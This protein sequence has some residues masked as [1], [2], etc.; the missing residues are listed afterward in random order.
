VT[1]ATSPG[2][3]LLEVHPTWSQCTVCDRY[4]TSDSAFTAHLD[5]EVSRTC[6]DPAT[7]RSG[8][9]RLVHDD[10]YGAW[11][12]QTGETPPARRKA[13]PPPARTNQE[14]PGHLR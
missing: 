1:R 12:W 5:S 4:F 13:P 8:D 11:R 14:R 10:E 9:R 7:V 3:R 6:H 2:V